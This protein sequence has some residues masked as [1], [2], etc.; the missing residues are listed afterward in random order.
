SNPVN[1]RER[2][3]AE[4]FAVVRRYAAAY[5]NHD[6]QEFAEV[7]PTISSSQLRTLADSFSAAKRLE[8]QLEPQ[9]QPSFGPIS[10][11]T[12]HPESAVVRCWRT[13]RMT[14]YGGATKTSEG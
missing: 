14:P 5:R 9:G 10:S 12:H 3:V 13:V 6:V 4:V 7:Y 11:V 8:V 1:E 2:D